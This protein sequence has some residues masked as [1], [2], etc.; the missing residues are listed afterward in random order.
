MLRSSI[1]PQTL[2]GLVPSPRAHN[3]YLQYHSMQMLLRQATTQPS[4]EFRRFEL[5]NAKQSNGEGFPAP[6]VEPSSDPNQVFTSMDAV[7]TL[8]CKPTKNLVDLS[9]LVSC[10]LE[11]KNHSWRSPQFYFQMR[12]LSRNDECQAKLFQ[13]IL[14]NCTDFNE[15]SYSWAEKPPVITLTSLTMRF[16][17]S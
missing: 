12:Q 4:D 8:Q 2:P 10:C 16:S 5:K 9:H 13:Q 11:A 14:R 17:Q 15:D 1:R 3:T 6:W 7:S